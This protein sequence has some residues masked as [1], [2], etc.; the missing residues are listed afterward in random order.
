MGGCLLQCSSSVHTMPVSF[1]SIIICDFFL[2]VD[3][4]KDKTEWIYLPNE[5]GDVIYIVNSGQN[6]QFIIYNEAFYENR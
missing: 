5:M 3:R 2:T 1:N 6:P 4:N